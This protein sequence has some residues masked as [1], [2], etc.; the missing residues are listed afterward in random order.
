MRG[1]INQF[2]KKAKSD[3]KLEFS[4]HKKQSNAALEQ[5]DKPRKQAFGTWSGGSRGFGDC[6]PVAHGAVHKQRFDDLRFGVSRPWRGDVCVSLEK[7]REI[8]SSSALS[9]RPRRLK[10]KIPPLERLVYAAWLAECRH[11]KSQT[12]TLEKR[13]TKKGGLRSVFRKFVT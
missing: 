6:R 8:L 13:K 12:P 2:W 10:N 5:A 7:R 3:E 1:S 11:L 4:Q 9:T